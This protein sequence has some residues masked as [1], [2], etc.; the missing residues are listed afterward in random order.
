MRKIRHAGLLASALVAAGWAGPSGAADI[1]IEKAPAPARLVF[2]WS[3][4]YAGI[5]VGYSVGRNPT[6]QTV[7][8]GAGCRSLSGQFIISPVGIVGGLQAGFNWQTA[9]HWVFGVEADVQGSGQKDT[10]CVLSC[11]TSLLNPTSLTTKQSLEWFGT[12]R[13]RIG[14]AQHGWL[15]Y[16]TGGG[17]VGQIKTD[18]AF[19]DLPTTASGNFGGFRAGWVVG[20]GVETALPGDW[21][22][23]LEYLYLDL[24]TATS[25][26]AFNAVGLFVGGPGSVVSTSSDIRDHIIRV[27][28]NYRFGAPA[29]SY[30]GQY[31]PVY[32]AP[33]Y[34]PP[35]VDWS[36]L[37]TGINIGYGV[38]RDPTTQTLCDT[39][40]LGLGCEFQEQFKIGP[41]G[42]IG[43]LQAG[44]NWHAARNWVV[45]VEGDIQG[46]AQ[47][48]TVC[49]LGC[50]T[51][52]GAI[53]RS[54]TIDQSLEW[55]GTLRGRI[56]YAQSGWLWYVTGGGAV[57]QINTSVTGIVTTTGL[58]GGTASTAS[59][60]SR[61][62]KGGWVVGAGVETTITGNFSWK[63]EYLFLDFGNVTTSPITLNFFP[64]GPFTGAVGSTLRDH[65]IRVGVNYRFGGPVVANY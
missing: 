28:V 44:F 32:K 47:K 1:A 26:L 34:A 41:A 60:T 22:W 7:C 20:G 62:T 56:G 50:V 30:A 59:V 23:R 27:A 24:G 51:N 19:I 65:V 48:D 3:G 10:T 5:N 16:V 45:G 6:T 31:D 46:S 43:G 55:F 11:S 64:F 25:S 9:S 39:L 13:G 53:A 18:L 17:A 15:W 63:L 33:S 8:L 49:V 54:S 42:F 2:D 14:Y 57:G 52:A 36:G 21:S 4:F 58:G 12:L 40:G 38:G 61:D 29:S 35:T 37:Y